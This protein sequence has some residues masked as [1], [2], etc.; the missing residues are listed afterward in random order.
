MLKLHSVQYQNLSHKLSN[1]RRLEK[2]NSE[3]W[4]GDRS[5][6]LLANS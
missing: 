3:F 6:A 1:S 2:F 4:R 5:M